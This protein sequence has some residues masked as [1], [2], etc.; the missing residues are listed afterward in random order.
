MSTHRHLSPNRGRHSMIDPMRASTGTVQMGSS[1]DPYD[2]PRRHNY[3]DYPSD[4]GYASAYGYRPA[5]AATLEA[6]PVSSQRIHDS[7][8][9][10]KKRTEYS[11]Q[12]TRHR[13][14]TAA[15]DFYPQIRLAAPQTSRHHISPV[16]HPAHRSS[17]NPPSASEPHV[18]PASPR[19]PAHP[20]HLRMYSTDYTSDNGRRDPRDDGR[21][22]PGHGSPRNYLPSQPGRHPAYDGLRKGD[23]IDEFDAYSYT[24]PREQF[25]R[26]YP[27]K[28]RPRKHRYSLDRPMSISGME[29]SPQWVTRKERPHGPPPTSWGFD[30]IP[31]ERQR[32]ST[33][34]R[35]DYRDSH[36]P[37]EGGHEQALVA[38]PHDSDEEYLPRH[39]R[40]HRRHRRHHESDR[41]QQYGDHHT[42][43]QDSG[44]LTTMGLGT[45][46]LGG[47]Y[48]DVE[49]FDHHRPSR[50]V[51]RRSH[52]D[53]E[54]RS[55]EPGQPTSREL[56]TS[57]PGTERSSQGFLDPEDAHRHGRR[58]RSRRRTY[59]NDADTSD[60]DLQRY[61]EEAAAPAHPRQVTN[62]STDTFESE[63]D[64]SRD[65][66][67]H[68]R[69]RDHSRGHR[70][71][72]SRHRFLEDGTS[73]EPRRSPP[74]DLARDD[75]KKLVAV[76]P[77]AGPKEPEAPPKGILKAPREAFPEEPNPVRE[78]VAPLKDATK[79]GIPPGAR[80]TKID[81][82]LVNPEALEAGN[83]RFEE[84]SDYVIVLRVLSKEE[85]QLY[86]VKTQ[87]IRDTRHK[88]QLRE[89][90]KS[91]DETQRHGRRGEESSSDD[92]DEGDDEHV[93]QLE[94]PRDS[95]EWRPVL[96]V[97]PRESNTSIPEGERPRTMAPSATP[98]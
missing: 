72:R 4:T 46:A 11:I 92:E 9:S 57:T 69:H 94:G 20:P 59:H 71:S 14:N 37:K 74:S 54:G 89:R 80:W 28:P 51:H 65:R 24:T 3:E 93:K 56:V 52:D 66:S 75:P 98:A 60:D 42:K 13:S 85:I 16:Q 31:R 50:R 39:E 84:R 67:R 44:S 17:P 68:R 1:Y 29:D 55:H 33:R 73:S 96:P 76:E 22:R 47:G 8:A 38:V 49:D 62:S 53:R 18:V 81:R 70:S 10:A 45:A 88:E 48:S 25:D 27:V 87:E 97:R 21:H 36:R 32:S 78:G 7:T 86:A 34:R 64:R 35:D 61:R 12:P 41:D 91:R 6:H 2:A 58:R 95:D 23:D 63:R 82:R 15:A 5:R 90:R 40:S 19:H 79:E 26:D 83:E 43:P 77:P 30:K